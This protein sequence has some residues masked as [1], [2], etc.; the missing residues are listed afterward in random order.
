[1]L[2]S[3]TQSIILTGLLSGGLFIFGILDI[4]ENFIVLTL[5]SIMFLLI[6]ANVFYVHFF[7]SKKDK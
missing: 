3:N 4:L 6:V 5:L 7:A 1:M 2:I